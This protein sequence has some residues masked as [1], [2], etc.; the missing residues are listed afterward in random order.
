MIELAQPPSLILPDHYLANRP[1]IIRP[2]LDVA[3]YFPV[4]IDRKTRRAIVSDLVSKGRLAPEQARRVVQGMAF[5]YPIAKA[6]ASGPDPEL[7]FRR[8]QRGSTAS[9]TTHTYTNVPIGAA[10]A[11]RVVYAVGGLGIKRNPNSAT[12]A[13]SAATML[14][15]YGSGQ[16]VGARG[17]YRKVPTGTTATISIVLNSSQSTDTWLY[18]WTF[19]GGDTPLDTGGSY[20]GSGTST[21]T[22]A[23]IAIA[24]G[25]VLIV[26]SATSSSTYGWEGVDV[27]TSDYAEA[28]F[29]MSSTETTEDTTTDDLTVARAAATT[30]TTGIVSFAPP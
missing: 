8:V 21:I 11:N 17:F 23:D 2:G 30:T 1:A 13:G 16:D 7:A 29:M 24:N 12:I 3:R 26:W 22:Y 14:T 25:G 4:E 27:L 10:N 19:I 15:H 9:S 20:T 28:G 18:V 5:P 6:G